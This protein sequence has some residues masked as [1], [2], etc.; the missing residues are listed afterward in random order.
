[1]ATKEA[2]IKN[3]AAQIKRYNNAIWMGDLEA[4]PKLLTLYHKNGIHRE[5]VQ[6]SQVAYHWAHIYLAARHPEGTRIAIKLFETLSNFCG[7]FESMCILFDLYAGMRIKKYDP[8]FMQ[9]ADNL[10]KL[11]GI[12]HNKAKAETNPQK[13]FIFYDRAIELYDRAR[14]LGNIDAIYSLAQCYDN[15]PQP[16]KD[17]A[18]EWYEVS[19]R[20]G[21]ID[22]MYRLCD[23]YLQDIQSNRSKI[24]WLANKL[25]ESAQFYQNIPGAENQERVIKLYEHASLLGHPAAIEHIRSM[26][27]PKLSSKSVVLDSESKRSLHTISAAKQSSVLSSSN[28][29]NLPENILSQK[30]ITR[31]MAK[32]G[33]FKAASTELYQ[34]RC[35]I[36]HK[37]LSSSAARPGIQSK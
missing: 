21:S 10:Y 16:E 34:H 22:A 14:K 6:L 20:R 33:T 13:A 5:A 19:S 37:V 17:L 27:M 15:S 12:Y 29:E 2:M 32:L 3:L 8:K 18:I 25:Y 31:H 24:V 26:A 23:I 11:A 4:V 36:N 35:C 30:K 28:K 1:M 9:L 7:H